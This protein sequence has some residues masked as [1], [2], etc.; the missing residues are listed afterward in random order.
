MFDSLPA[1]SSLHSSDIKSTRVRAVTKG[2]MKIK[3]KFAKEKPVAIPVQR[4]LTVRGHAC[5]IV[6]LHPLGT[7]D[8]VSRCGNYAFR[9]S[10]L[11]F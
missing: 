6:K 8:V 7:L 2:N 9:V 3:V 11:S 5:H 1:R 10:G 4:V